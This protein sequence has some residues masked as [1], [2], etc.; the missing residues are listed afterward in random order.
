MNKIYLFC[1]KTT[2][3]SVICIIL[4]ASFTIPVMAME[5]RDSRA[6]DIVIGNVSDMQI[7]SLSERDIFLRL[8]DERSNAF[9]Q[10]IVNPNEVNRIDNL[11]TAIGAVF[12]SDA[13]AR[14]IFSDGSPQTLSTEQLAALTTPQI[15]L[16]RVPIINGDNGIDQWITFESVVW[17]FSEC[18]TGFVPYHFVDI[19][20]QPSVH[21]NGRSRLDQS[22]VTSIPLTTQWQAGALVL[23]RNT[24]TTVIGEIPGI[25][26]AITFFN[27]ANGIIPALTGASTVTGT[28]VSYAWDS[29]QN[30]LFTYVNRAG[31]HEHFFM[32]ALVSSRATL[33][34]RTTIVGFRTT[35][36]W[37]QVITDN[38][39]F[40][41]TVFATPAGFGSEGLAIEAFRRGRRDDRRIRFHEIRGPG[42]RVAQR[43]NFI[44]QEGPLG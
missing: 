21:N 12:I 7:V 34:I 16:H 3:L 44:L 35:N 2:L 25:S 20:H 4:T 36:Q 37:G 5:Q 40:T 30:N 13:Q 38:F 14:T 32:Q 15:Q 23:L 6:R 11:L 10:E 19:F 26:T 29:I 27:I 41:A 17:W 24:A 33:S 42:D 1:K 18:G 43:I 22:G 31:Q 28:S 8:I 9:A 39:S